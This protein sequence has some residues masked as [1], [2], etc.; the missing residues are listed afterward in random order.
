MA[1]AS[2]PDGAPAPVVIESGKR[3]RGRTSCD[4]MFDADDALY[5]PIIWIVEADRDGGL[6]K[7]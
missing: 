7:I 1:L 2:R 3:S 5:N 6:L 4:R